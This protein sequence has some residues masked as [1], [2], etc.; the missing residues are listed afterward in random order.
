[1]LRP[2]RW[3]KQTEEQGEVATHAD[4]QSAI[5][6]HIRVSI[7]TRLGEHPYDSSSD[8]IRACSQREVTAGVG[9]E[10]RF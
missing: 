9:P 2:T 4:L 1:V 8:A 7:A 3:A 5:S 10:V 6:P